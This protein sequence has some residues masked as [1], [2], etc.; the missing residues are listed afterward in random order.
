[1]NLRFFLVASIVLLALAGCSPDGAPR[2]GPATNTEDPVKPTEAIRAPRRESIQVTGTIHRLAEEGGVYVIRTTDG[3]Q[4]R[5]E[6]L[7]P[8]FRV[9]GLAVAAEA[10]LHDDVMTKDQPGQAIDLVEIRKTGG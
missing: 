6:E 3:T 9:E 1:M 8:D 2:V 5:P 10:L 4:Y 7:P